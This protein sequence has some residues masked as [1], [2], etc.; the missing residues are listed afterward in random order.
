[1]NILQLYRDF[2]IQFQTEGHKH[3]RPGW[4]NT[5]CPFCTGNPGYH[6]G[7]TIDGGHC[8]CWRCGWHPVIPTIAK[9]LKVSLGQAR[10]TI[11]QYGGRAYAIQADLKI[12]VKAHKLPSSTSALSKQART[13]LAKRMFDPEKLEATWG[14]LS[15]GPISILDHINF[16]HRIIAPIIWEGQ[17]VSFQARDYTGKSNLRYITCP[18]DRELVFH[19]NIVYGKQEAWGDTG[20]CVEGITD[21]WR[22][23]PKA[24]ATFGIEY[25]QTQMRLI[26]KLFKKV[27][28]V[29]DDDPQAVVQAVKLTKDLGL[30]GV[31]SKHIQIVG[32]PGS[33]NQGEADYLVRQLI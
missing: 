10:A 27:Y 16:K 26:S 31:I 18:K 1:M 6:L 32:D 14:L 12:K 15:T 11:R 33:L 7:F 28:V 20:I 21:V 4:V 2:G 25:T 17:Q 5:S 29:F 8:Y 3:C 9:L 22:L 13:Y 23:G 19:K 30:R 24:F